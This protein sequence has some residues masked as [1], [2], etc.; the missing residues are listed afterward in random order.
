MQPEAAAVGNAVASCQAG[1]VPKKVDH[2]QR[3]ELLTEAVWD[4]IAHEGLSAVSLRSVAGRA[5]VSMGMVQHYFA[6]KDDMLSFA[7]DAL[8]RAVQTRLEGELAALGQAAELRDVVGVVS[9]ELLPL[10]DQ[11]DLEARVTL[12]FVAGAAVAPGFAELIAS[13]SSALHEF[14]ADC[15]GK[16]AGSRIEDG[17]WRASLLLAA[18]DGLSQ[19]LVLGIHDRESGLRALSRVLELVARAPAGR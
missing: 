19:Q 11:R 3:R 8:G 13:R 7:L 14:L 16:I 9:R 10:D 15:L 18:L 12:A 4:L 6:T 17:R 5:G 2:Q 1:V